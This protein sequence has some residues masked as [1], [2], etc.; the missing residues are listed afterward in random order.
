MMSVKQHTHRFH[1]G[2]CFDAM[3]KHAFCQD[4]CAVSSFKGEAARYHEVEEIFLTQQARQHQTLRRDR[5][6]RMV[7][8][9]HALPGE[10]TDTSNA[11]AR[12]NAL[13][14]SRLP[15]L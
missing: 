8:A 9:H 14:L 2:I 11:H 13:H 7:A 12:Y 1:D 3:E 10:T 6:P 5:K 4:A 15:V